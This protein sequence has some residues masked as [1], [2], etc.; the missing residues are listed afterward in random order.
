M[1][2]HGEKFTRNKEQAVMALLTQPTV[3]AAAAAAGVS[4]ATL[5]RWRK[6]PE[7]Q[8][9]YHE[10][11]R[12]TLEEAMLRLQQA[13]NQAVETLVRNLTCGQ[14]SVEVRTAFGVLDQVLKT[15]ELM[16][17]EEGIDILERH[18]E[19]NAQ[20][21]NADV[22]LTHDRRLRIDPPPH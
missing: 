21:V 16:D 7:F 14:P 18:F 11:R 8:A 17:Q 3:D 12:R 15:H 19:E 5:W 2:G 10:V 1:K 13:A 4:S 9:Q 20:S 22:D 6:L